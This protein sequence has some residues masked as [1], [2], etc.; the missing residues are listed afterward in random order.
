M[1]ATLKARGGPN[2]R[3]R[4][5]ALIDDALTEGLMASFPA[6]DP[7]SMANTLIQGTKD[8]PRPAAIDEEQDRSDAANPFGKLPLDQGQRLSDKDLAVTFAFV[9]VLIA[10]LLMLHEA[11][12]YSFDLVAT[13]QMDVIAVPPM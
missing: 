4:Q 6:S 12:S 9:I 10:V 13:R 8:R 1:K 7:L 5:E 3:R 11:G 2:A